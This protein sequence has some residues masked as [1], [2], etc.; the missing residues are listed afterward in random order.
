[1]LRTAPGWLV[2]LERACSCIVA[3][4]VYPFVLHRLHAFKGAVYLCEQMNSADGTV[5]VCCSGQVGERLL[6][7]CVFTDVRGGL[8]R[9]EEAVRPGVQSA[10][11]S[12]GLMFLGEAEAGEDDDEEGAAAASTELERA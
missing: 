8:Y 5:A 9:L 2:V 4:R 7:T 11:A 10:A 3:A 1:M 6:L 12:E